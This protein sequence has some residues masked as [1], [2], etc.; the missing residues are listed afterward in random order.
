[1]YVICM[2]VY[3]IYTHTGE[4]FFINTRHEPIRNVCLENDKPFVT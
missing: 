1:M 2:Y 4:I 3:I